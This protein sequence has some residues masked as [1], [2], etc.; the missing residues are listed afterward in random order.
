MISDKL[1][2]LDIS[3]LCQQLREGKTGNTG[4]AVS[5]AHNFTGSKEV[6]GLKLVSVWLQGGK[7]GK[8]W[9]FKF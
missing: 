7:K 4:A 2:L 9:S 3:L 8:T 1:G 5:L 6:K